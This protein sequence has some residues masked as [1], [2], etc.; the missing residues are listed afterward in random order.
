MIKINLTPRSYVDKIYSSIFIAK[1]AFGFV[2]LI[3][4]LGVLSFMRYATLKGLEI[5][6]SSLEQEYKNLNEKVAQSKNIE[7]KIKEINNYISAVEKLN[8]NRFIY[9]AF[10]QDIIN[11]L[12]DTLW[13]G[14]IDTKTRGDYLEVSINLNSNSLEDLLWWYAFLENGSLRYSDIK[15][16][17][18][19][20]NGS[21]YNTQLTFSYKYNI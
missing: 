9:V 16:S 18:I 19:N 5:D 17:A 3:L 14:G 21:Y 8:K 4:V 20:F 1:I 11:N 7:T 15:I 2:L 13:F 6:Y 12:P 10:I